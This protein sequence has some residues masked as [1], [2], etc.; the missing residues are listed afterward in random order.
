MLLANAFVKSKLKLSANYVTQIVIVFSKNIFVR[1]IAHCYL[2][3]SLSSQLRSTICKDGGFLTISIAV[4]K[5]QLHSGKS[6]STINYQLSTINYQ[7]SKKGAGTNAHLDS[8]A[9]RSGLLGVMYHQPPPI[10]RLIPTPVVSTENYQLNLVH[11][12]PAA[13]F[14]LESAN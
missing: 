2:P 5:L 14:P 4:L 13:T 3:E 9:D 1:S 12:L 11:P 6:L 7:L 8:W 10:S